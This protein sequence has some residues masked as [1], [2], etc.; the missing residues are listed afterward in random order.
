MNSIGII[1]VGFPH[2]EI[3]GQNWIAEAYHR[4]LI[5]AP[6]YSLVLGRYQPAD[7][8]DGSLMIIGGYDEDLVDGPLTWVPCSGT[9]HAQIP[10]DG[11]IVN[12]Q[13]IKRADNRPMQAIIDVFPSPIN[14][15]NFSLE[16]ADSSQVLQVS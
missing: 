10:L 11:I 5:P 9:S 2:P 15:A 7:L 6:V 8:T 16:L 4:S 12:G 3:P 1:G 14:L 13:T